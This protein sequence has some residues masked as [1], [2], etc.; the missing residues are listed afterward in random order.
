MALVAEMRLL[1]AAIGKPFGVK[2]EVTVR[3]HTD[4]PTERLAVGQTLW[5]VPQGSRGA[6]STGE[7]PDEQALTIIGA[8]FTPPGGVLRLE[9]VTNRNEAESLRGRELW[10]E[11]AEDRQAADLEEWY[12]HELVGLPCVSPTGEGLGEVIEV[13]HHPAHDSLVVRTESGDRFVPFV[14][15]IIPE[16]TD[17]HVVVDDPG[18]LLSDLPASEK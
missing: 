1:V 10:A 17:E 4:E 6:E 3:L 13:A 12:D 8:R 5:A 7:H 9:G 2:G 18:G 14:S 15:E 11:V 16:V